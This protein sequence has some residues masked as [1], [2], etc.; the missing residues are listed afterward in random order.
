MTPSA[1]EILEVVETLAR[2]LTVPITDEMRAGGWRDESAISMSE[3]LDRFAAKIRLVGD[4][5]P[6]SE[7]PWDMI[8]GLDS[9]GIRGGG[10]YDELLAL[11]SS[12]RKA[13]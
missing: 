11:G 3:A 12:L 2:R 5:P 9:Q 1:A 8:R 10:P 4:L 7:R 6:K 13:P